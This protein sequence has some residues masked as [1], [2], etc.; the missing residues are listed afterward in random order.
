MKK[1][2]YVGLAC[3]LLTIFGIALDYYSTI[4]T[5]TYPNT[6]EGN[7]IAAEWIKNNIFE[8]MTTLQITAIAGATLLLY[9]F[10]SG[11]SAFLKKNDPDS[12]HG[13][14]ILDSIFLISFLLL[15][16]SGIIRLTAAYGNFQLADHLAK[17]DFIP[18]QIKTFVKA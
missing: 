6:Q 11:F 12:K 18:F 7:P 3:S 17:I 4:T 1:L 2:Y 9:I 16:L 15:A 14:H 5:L 10:H 8:E 13:Q